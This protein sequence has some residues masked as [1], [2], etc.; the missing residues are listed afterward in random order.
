MAHRVLLLV[1]RN[2]SHATV[3]DCAADFFGGTRRRFSFLFFLALLL[4]IRCR[5]SNAL[6]DFSNED[7]KNGPT[8]V[9]PTGNWAI[10]SRFVCFVVRGRPG[11]PTTMGLHSPRS[12]PRSGQEI[13]HLHNLCPSFAAATLVREAVYSVC[14]CECAGGR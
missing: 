5:V 3:S 1:P 9:A 7:W 11:P 6:P 8:W 14:V 4:Q 10:D 13:H 2:V 12:C